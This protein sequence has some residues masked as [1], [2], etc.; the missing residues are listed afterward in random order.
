MSDEAYYTERKVQD[1][2]GAADNSSTAVPK[3]AKRNWRIIPNFMTITPPDIHIDRAALESKL[4]YKYILI[5]FLIVSIILSS[6]TVSGCSSSSSSLANIYLLELKYDGYKQSALSGAGVINVGAYATFNSNVNNTDL[7]V[8]ISYF[9]TCVNSTYSYNTTGKDWYCNQ[10]VTHVA[11]TLTSQDQDPF[12]AIYLMNQVRS[13]IVSPALLIISIVFT[14]ISMIVLMAAT[15]QQPS[16]FFTATGLTLF[17]CFMALVSLIWQQVSVDT[18]KSI[19]NNLSNNAILATAGSVPAG[20]GWT[21]VFLLFGVSVG[22]VAL[23]V[24]E[25]QALL[26]LK[27]FG[28]DFEE[29]Q[30]TYGQNAFDGRSND[31]SAI[32][33]PQYNNPQYPNTAKNNVAIPTPY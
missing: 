13:N 29:T 2:P 7:T 15:L 1:H 28:S 17:S 24:N 11:E 19:L 26:S 5:F 23:V 14:F 10:N 6:V 18:A 30:K 16:F 25:K 20:L 4:R 27:E 31:D 9:G 21:S 3:Q 33:F 22:I 8:R 12:N 32:D